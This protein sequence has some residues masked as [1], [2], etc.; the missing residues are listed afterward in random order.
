MK[1]R[2]DVILFEAVLPVVVGMKGV[3]MLTAPLLYGETALGLSLTE[4]IPLVEFNLLQL[5]CSAH[6][7]FLI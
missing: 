7:N 2:L 1:C 4:H 3:A 5:F 6:E